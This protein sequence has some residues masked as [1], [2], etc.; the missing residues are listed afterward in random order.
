LSGLRRREATET[1]AAATHRVNVAECLLAAKTQPPF[2]G[3][4]LGVATT[5]DFCLMPV[6]R[7][8]VPG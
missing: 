7:W 4:I 2:R 5:L 1:C 3:L 8:G 6:A